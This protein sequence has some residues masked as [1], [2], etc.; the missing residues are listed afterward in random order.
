MTALWITLALAVGCWWLGYRAGLSRAYQR[1]SGAL[2]RVD[3]VIGT[4]E[5]IVRPHIQDSPIVQTGEYISEGP[6]HGVVF[7]DRPP[8]VRYPEARVADW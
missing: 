6:D 4:A 7:T 8:A 2:G 5:A 3:G 1:V